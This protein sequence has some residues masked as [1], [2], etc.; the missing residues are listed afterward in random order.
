MVREEEISVDGETGGKKES[1]L[2]NLTSID[3]FQM[4]GMCLLQNQTGLLLAKQRGSVY[5]GQQWY[6]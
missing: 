1:V 5:A 2:M 6:R 3:R 4:G